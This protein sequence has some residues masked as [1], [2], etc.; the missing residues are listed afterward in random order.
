MGQERRKTSRLSL[1]VPV[2]VQG[3][4]AD[5][6]TWD[7]MTATEDAS[8]GGVSLRLKHPARLGLV[9]HLSM[10]FPKRLRSYDLT[11]PSYRIYALVRNVRATGPE[12]P[13]VGVMFI[14]RFPPRGAEALPAGVY[15]MP[16][17]PQPEERRRHQRISVSLKIK[18]QTTFARA[19]APEEEET[20]A[21]DIGKFGAKI[22]T[23]LPVGKGDQVLV[24]EVG[25]DYRTR[26]EIRNVSIGPDGHPRISLLFLDG[27]APERLLS[28]PPAE[29]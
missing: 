4:E 12:P 29:S 3:R 15:L 18:L 21:E 7:E 6:Q 1:R 20:L 11:D 10:P 14:G 27:P 2:R 13:R 19:G 5:G 25:G 28:A 9:L 8:T 16:G 24:E 23:S 22:K 26:A 17:D